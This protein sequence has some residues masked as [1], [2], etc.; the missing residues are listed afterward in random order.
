MKF[1]WV[2]TA[3]FVLT[4][5]ACTRAQSSATDAPKATATIKDIMDSMVDPSG[6]FLFESTAE[7]ADANGITHKAPHTD[8]EWEE[9]RRRALVLLEAPNLLVM[10]GRKV[11]N[12]SDKSKN[13][14][15]ELEPEKIQT[16]VDG[17]R[18]SF[19]RRARRLQDAAGLVLKAIEAKDKDALFH[20]LDGIDKACES[21][22]LHYWYPNDKRAQEAAKRDGIVD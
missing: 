9:V 2:L 6:D 19:I 17:D 7:I 1:T 15:I 22:H 10:E 12:P 13:P 14:E 18:P 16:L 3:I 5:S 21:C 11:A 8:E 4:G 20:S